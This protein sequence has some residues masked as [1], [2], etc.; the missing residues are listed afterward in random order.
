MGSMVSTLGMHSQEVEGTLGLLCGVRTSV[1][2][3]YYTQ[4]QLATSTYIEYVA[5]VREHQVT[6]STIIIGLVEPLI[7]HH[8]GGPH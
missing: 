5:I 8:A 7:V 6:L 4:S 2:H 1:V 3:N